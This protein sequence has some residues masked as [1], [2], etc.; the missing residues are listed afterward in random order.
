M[1][2]PTSSHEDGEG[3]WDLI[4][5]VECPLEIPDLRESTRRN[6]M[7]SHRP[8]LQEEECCEWDE[9]EK[10]MEA[11]GGFGNA[12]AVK[13]PVSPGG[14]TGALELARKLKQ[15]QTED[16]WK[17]IHIVSS[18]YIRCMETADAVAR[19]LD[20]SIKVEPGIAEVNSS[21]QPGFLAAAELKRQF[22]SVDATYAPAIDREELPMEYSDGACARR[23]ADAARMV[24]E[25]LEG[26]IL[27]VGHGASCLGV[28]D[29][30][31]QRGYVGYTS[32]TKF[33]REGTIW[34]CIAFGDVSHLS[35]RQTSLDSA[36]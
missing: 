11:K 13:V 3:I 22:P 21:R 20:A 25:R 15:L 8:P 14:I 31:G 5:F 10:R 29:Q 35:D 17:S 18:P 4:A 26:P 19:A 28:A 7:K 2:R 36:W 23:S 34:K 16:G 9:I 33:V 32:L 24:A 1:N 12:T 30:F 6:G 27:F